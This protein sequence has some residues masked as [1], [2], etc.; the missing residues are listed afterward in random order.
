MPRVAKAPERAGHPVVRGEPIRTCVG[1]RARDLRVRLA[2]V[3]VEHG[4]LCVDRTRHAPGRGA[5]LHT[6]GAC[7]EAF[8]RKG[9]FVRSLRCV[10]PKSDREML[11]DRFA[12][13]QA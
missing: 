8:A 12:E 2:R 10:I 1:C 13:E 9:G 3:V 5:Y 4:A 6:R 11:R 7:L